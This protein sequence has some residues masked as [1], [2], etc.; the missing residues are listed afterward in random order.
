MGP[1]SPESTRSET[2]RQPH[3][4]LVPVYRH[5]S[6]LKGKAVA[7]HQRPRNGTQKDYQP[8]IRPPRNIPHLGE[9]W[10]L[11]LVDFWKSGAGVCEEAAVNQFLGYITLLLRLS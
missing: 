5:R 8:S 1:P 6:G 10:N 3:T 11:H 2:G 4:V 7:R 9:Q